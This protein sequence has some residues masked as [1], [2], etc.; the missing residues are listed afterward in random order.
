[1]AY[2]GSVGTLTFI[3]KINSSLSDHEEQNAH[4]LLLVT[5]SLPKYATRDMKKASLTSTLMYQTALL[6]Y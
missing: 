2:G 4:A 1:M 3:W 6:W 5:E